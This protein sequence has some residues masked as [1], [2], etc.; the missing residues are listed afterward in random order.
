MYSGDEHYEDGMT[1]GPDL[2][3]L[4]GLDWNEANEYAQELDEEPPTETDAPAEDRESEPRTPEDD[5]PF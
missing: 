2:E 3:D 5:L 4:H 1:S